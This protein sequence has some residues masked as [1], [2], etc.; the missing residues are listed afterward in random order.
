MD[1][2]PAS[3]EKVAA[4]GAIVQGCPYRL[5]NPGSYIPLS[6]IFSFLLPGV[7]FSI[8]QG[9]L[10]GKRTRNLLC[11]LFVGGMIA[12]FTL[13]VLIDGISETA[14]RLGFLG[15]NVSIAGLLM[16]IQ[17]PDYRRWKTTGQ[18]P[19]RIV[20]PILIGLG[21]VCAIATVIIVRSI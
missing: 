8:N 17:M 15:I 11:A 5:Y 7:L 2:T 3:E 9:K 12:L 20:Y 19:R 1:G 21:L 16:T 6:I 4:E 13:A 10:H 14:G 18:R